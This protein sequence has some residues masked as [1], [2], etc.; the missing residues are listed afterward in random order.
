M[1]LK[2]LIVDDEPQIRDLI[3]MWLQDADFETRVAE[4][5]R[6][7]L[8]ML[9]NFQPDLVISDVWMPGMDGYDFC[10]MVRRNSNA[11]IIMMTGVPQE[12][13]VL[14]ESNLDI[15]GH[16]VKPFNRK[17]FISRIEAALQRRQ[18]HAT[19]PEIRESAVTPDATDDRTLSRDERLA[20]LY[21]TLS[22]EDK[23]LLLTIVERLSRSQ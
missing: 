15:D 19:E 7:G 1:T 10:R 12:A 8:Q 13:A 16:I 23:H 3:A 9:A 20:K 2:A 5:G 11:A 4:D 21:P 6:R 22:D 14:R 18:P 17:D